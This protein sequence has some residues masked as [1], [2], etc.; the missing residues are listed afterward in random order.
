MEN[1]SNKGMIIIIVILSLLLVG[2]SGYLVYDKMF[3]KDEVKE[4]GKTEENDD[5]VITQAEI[6]AMMKVIDSN[7]DEVTNV[8]EFNALENQT[9]LNMSLSL[10]DTSSESIKGSELITA[11]KNI[12]GDKA[13]VTLE[14][15]TCGICGKDSLIYNK[16]TDLYT[17]A[18]GDVHPGHGASG[19]DYI[20]I[21]N[22]FESVTKS[23]SQY[24]VVVKKMVSLIAGCDIGPCDSNVKVYKSLE[25]AKNGKNIILDTKETTNNKNYCVGYDDQS[26]KGLT[27]ECDIDKIYHDNKDKLDSYT[28]TFIKNGDNYIFQNYELNK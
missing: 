19:E 8:D 27:K 23:D 13:E 28:Y 14:D 1:K 15:I 25:D 16:T 9:K 21:V 10:I 26:L 11:L 17:Y 7:P 5:V 20:D 22:Y 24:K 3:S 12:Y 6:D 18:D 4:K 2:V